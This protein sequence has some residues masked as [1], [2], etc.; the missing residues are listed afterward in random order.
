MGCDTAGLFNEPVRALLRGDGRTYGVLFATDITGATG[1]LAIKVKL[2][3]SDAAAKVL[4]DGTLDV[5]DAEN[6]IYR[7]FFELTE[8]M[9]AGLPLGSV[10]F[11][12]RITP[13]GGRPI[14]VVRQSVPVYDT[15]P[16]EVP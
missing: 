10:W 14:T 12:I 7:M 2:T 5:P 6:K 3:D 15:L 9:T 11:G 4:I 8:E 13:P 16:N 1:R